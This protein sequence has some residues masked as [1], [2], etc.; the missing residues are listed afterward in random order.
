M[1]D[2]PRSLKFERPRKPASFATERFMV[3]P[4]LTHLLSD[5]LTAPS[6]GPVICLGDMMHQTLLLFSER[7]LPAGDKPVMST[8][9]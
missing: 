2:I 6:S 4:H 8:G 9:A 1:L 5:P 3:H 7:D